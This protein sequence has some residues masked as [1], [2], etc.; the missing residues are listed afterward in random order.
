MTPDAPAPAERPAPASRPTRAVLARLAATLDGLLA[1][2]NVDKLWRPTTTTLLVDLRA[3]GKERLLIDLEQR[4]ARVLVT[5]RWPETPASP[6]RE[7]LV[8]RKLL[9][10]IR[11]ARVEADADRRLVFR[12]EPRHDARLHMIVQLAG[13]YP[14]VAVLDAGGAELVRLVH[15][16]PGVD[17]DAPALPDGPDAHAALD[18]RAWLEAH[19]RSSW[20]AADARA[21]AAARDRLLRDTRAQRERVARRATRHEAELDEA[22]GAEAARHRADLLKSALHRVR[23]GDA[24]VEVEDWADPAL[25][26]VTL[27]I[28][29]QRTPVEEL[30]HLYTRY[31]RLVRM[32]AEAERRLEA[33][34]S[35]LEALDSLAREITAATDLETLAA[36]APRLANVGAA[37]RRQAPPRRRDEAVARAPYRRFRAADGSDILVGRSAADN[38]ALTFRVASGRDI[39]LHARDLPGSHVILRAPGGG[40][41]PA[42]EAMIDAATLAAWSS[43]ARGEAVVDVAWTERKHVRKVPGVPGRVTIADARTLTVR[44]EQARVDRLYAT[45]SRDDSDSA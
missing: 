7:T 25:A 21:L 3:L 27:T 19:A 30:E 4:H 11:V 16:R 26:R 20:E 40:R 31:K 1:G 23:P 2:T 6:D 29:P 10:G 24:T 15:A 36:L 39:F 37:P 28:D 32:R 34:W 5:P 13:R 38:D 8:L 41:A 17:P 33:A 14:N 45:L 22:A 35:E 9:E 43:K 42:H 44:V 12:F 18:G